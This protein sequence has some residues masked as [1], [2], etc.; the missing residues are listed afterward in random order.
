VRVVLREGAT[1]DALEQA[2]APLLASE[3]DWHEASRRRNAAM[4]AL[5]GS[6][7]GGLPHG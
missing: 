7:G 2:L 6:S 4:R 3:Q 1:L 5:I